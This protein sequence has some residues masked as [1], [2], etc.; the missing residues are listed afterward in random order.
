MSYLDELS[1]R[2]IADQIPDFGAP[3]DDFPKKLAL[4]RNAARDVLAKYVPSFTFDVGA[5]QQTM[6]EIDSWADRNDAALQTVMA[7]PNTKDLGQGLELTLGEPGTQNFVIA[8]FTSAAAGL[9]P[10]MSGRMAV[11]QRNA[12][13]TYTAAAQEDAGT[14]LYMFGLIV[15]MD[16]DGTLAQIYRPS[17]AAGFGI[18]P[19][20]A[21][22][23]ATVALAAVVLTYLFMTRRADV[24]NRLMADMC[25]KAQAD[26][27]KQTVQACIEATRDLQTSGIGDIP[28]TLGKVIVTLGALYL[29]VAYVLPALLRSSKPSRA[30]AQNPFGARSR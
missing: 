8:G 18:F 9:G 3:G 15:K 25:K 5:A 20:V 17:A 1:A 4:G 16:Q 26:G 27:D 30:V 29:G 24:N 13:G 6:R 21:L 7:D 28:G 14:R 22:F 12:D 10:W 11:E 2:R 19:W 23:V